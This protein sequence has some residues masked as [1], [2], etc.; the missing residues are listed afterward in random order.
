MDVSQPLIRDEVAFFV[1]MDGAIGIFRAGARGKDA[2]DDEQ[3][4]AGRRPTG[5]ADSH[6]PREGG[7]SLR[8][9]LCQVTST[10]LLAPDG[11]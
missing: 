2:P 7:G 5:I 1:A 3:Q 11:S 8:W 6:P 9:Y 4:Q 10:Q